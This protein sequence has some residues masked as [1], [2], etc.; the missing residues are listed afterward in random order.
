[1]AATNDFK[2][3]KYRL[4]PSRTGEDEVEFPSVLARAFVPSGSRISSLLS[5]HPTRRGA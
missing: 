1:M 3:L 2:S 4:Y 5:R